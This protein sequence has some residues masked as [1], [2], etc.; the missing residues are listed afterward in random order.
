MECGHRIEVRLDVPEEIDETHDEQPDRQPDQSPR[1]AL[2]RT[3]EQHH[4]RH[5]EMKHDQQQT[6]NLPS[7]IQPPR[8]E[9]DFLRQVTGP[10]NQ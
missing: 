7:L 8:E 3:R 9:A 4:K 6:D 1:V 10:D 5:S 2:E